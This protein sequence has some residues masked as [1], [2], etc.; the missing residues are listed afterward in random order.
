MK[1][2]RLVLLAAAVVSIALVAAAVYF[3]IAD[4]MLPCPW[5]VIQRYAFLAIALTCFV[6]AALPERVIRIG[7]GL[8]FLESLAG[9]G[10]ASWLL[11]VKAHPAV[12]CGIDPVETALNKVWTAQWLPK[13]FEANGECTT[14]YP[15]ILGLTVAQWS[16]TWFIILAIVLGWTAFKRTR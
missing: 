8:A 1:N 14:E 15:P 12:S 16:F 11:W 10:A 13:L 4:R 6:S 5:C 3:Q 2:P 9:L 7:A